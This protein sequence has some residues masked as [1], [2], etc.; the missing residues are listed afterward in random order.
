LGAGRRDDADALVLHAL[1]ISIGLGFVFTVIMLVWGRPIYRLLGGT[2][3]DLEAALIYSNVVFAG[4]VL[5]WAMN[6][7]ASVI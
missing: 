6:G 4:N 7:L 1:V 5:L 2:A 3:G